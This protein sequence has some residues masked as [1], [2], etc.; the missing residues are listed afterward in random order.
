MGWPPM[1]SMK[2]FIL[3]MRSRWIHMHSAWVTRF[4]SGGKGTVFVTL[5]MINPKRKESHQLAVI[6]AENRQLSTTLLIGTFVKIYFLL[7]KSCCECQ[8]TH[9]L[10]QGRNSKIVRT[11]HNHKPHLPPPTT[12]HR[13][14]DPPILGFRPPSDFRC[15]KADKTRGRNLFLSVVSKSRDGSRR[16]Q[17]G[18]Q[19]P[20]RCKIG[21]DSR[22]M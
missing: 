12:H 18:F 16:S 8:R 21:V 17:A 14:I 19:M 15:S 10:N 4:P 20:E 9:P 22:R 5:R 11:A 13:P 3:A 7:E 2:V 1:D 6:Y